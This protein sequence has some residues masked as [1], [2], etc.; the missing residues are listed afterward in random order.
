MVVV[1]VVVG[2]RM[3]TAPLPPPKKMPVVVLPKPTAPTPP[4]TLDQIAAAPGQA[5]DK[6]R[7]AI[8]ARRASEQDRIDALAAGNDVPDKRALDTPPP[9]SLTAPVPKALAPAAPERVTSTSQLAPGVTV[10]TTVSD[11][12]GVASGPF[13][14]WVANARISGVFQG[15]PARA[16]I[17]GRMVRAG[18][19][20][21]DALGIMFDGVDPV[22]ESLVFR[23]KTGA[24]VVRKF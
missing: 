17:N 6:A 7:D 14:E 22:G 23:D 20:V 2:Y 10:T 11:V 12:A 16:L 3:L 4:V 13:R 8:A 21:D 19:I 1:A 15:T 18:Q 9:A 5:I 24:T